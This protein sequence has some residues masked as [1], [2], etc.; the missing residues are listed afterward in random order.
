MDL[1]CDLVATEVLRDIVEDAIEESRAED[2]GKAAAGIASQPTSNLSADS[3]RPD[4]HSDLGNMDISCQ[5]NPTSA[6]LLTPVSY[7]SPKETASPKY[8]GKKMR[9]KPKSRKAVDGTVEVEAEMK[10]EDVKAEPKHVKVVIRNRDN[11]KAFATKAIKPNSLMTNRIV[12]YADASSNDKEGIQGAG[13][14]YK[15]FPSESKDMVWNDESYG[16][17]GTHSISTAE[18]LAIRCAL[19]IAVRE[20]SRY[21]QLAVTKTPHTKFGVFV[22]TDSQESLQSIQRFLSSDRKPSVKEAFLYQQSSAE[23]PG[24]LESLSEAGA[25]IELHWVPGH[26]GVIGN[27]RADRLACDA[28]E[29]VRPIMPYHPVSP[30]GRDFEIISV[31]EMVRERI[32]REMEQERVQ[33]VRTDTQSSSSGGFPGQ[34]KTPEEILLLLDQIKMAVEGNIINQAN[35]LAEANG[36]RTVDSMRL[37]TP[38]AANQHFESESS[39]STVVEVAS[40]VAP[41]APAALGMDSANTGMVES[42]QPDQESTAKHNKGKHM[43]TGLRNPFRRVSGSIRKWRAVEKEG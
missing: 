41:V 7:D 34:A 16:I 13:V 28:V 12:F 4:L 21:S 30:D 5:E 3:Q 31:R 15:Y 22:F 29:A 43:F 19:K 42:T 8:G 33:M 18:M 6:A 36:G 25:H 35:L 1:S 38:T 2:C 20:M 37:D 32:N 40:P 14:T 23:I 9:V 27:T 11:A 24:L 17:I 10:E 39:E 26:C